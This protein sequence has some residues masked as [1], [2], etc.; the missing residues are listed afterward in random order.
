MSTRLFTPAGSAAGG[1][2]VSGR[3]GVDADDRLGD[4]VLTQAPWSR[5]PGARVEIGARATRG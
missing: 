2:A 1:I 4:D 3:T 5:C